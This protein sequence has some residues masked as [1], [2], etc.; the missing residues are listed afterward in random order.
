MANEI[1]VKVT[2]T[3][4]AAR[5]AFRDV[6]AEMSKMT[7]EFASNAKEAVNADNGL[8]RLLS[9]IDPVYNAEKKLSDAVGLLDQNLRLGN[10]TADAHAS[11]LAKVESVYG[12]ASG[13]AGGLSF[14]TSGV[15]REFI[16][17]G[18]EVISGNFS[19]IPGS[20]LVL[21]ERMG[22]LNLATIGT[23][24]A[25]AA[26]AFA[27]YEWA[28]HAERTAEA[29]NDLEAAERGFAQTA[30]LGKSQIEDLINSLR[31]LPGVN[32]E[33]AQSI[34]TEFARAH[35]VSGDQIRE[36][37]KYVNDFAFVTGQKAPAAAKE[38]A[39]A[40]NDPVTGVKELE[41]EF[42][43]FTPEQLAAIT[44]FNNLG[45]SA[46]AAAVIMEAVEARFKD[47]RENSLTPL[48]KTLNDVALAWD[49][50][51]NSANDEDGLAGLQAP[52]PH[53]TVSYDGDPGHL[54]DEEA[55]AS[56]AKS[57]ATKAERD[58]NDEIKR[59]IE[60][61]QQMGLQIAKRSELEG[62]LAQM[63]E[64]QRAA[65]EAGDT[66]D[67]A[68]FAQSAGEIQRQIAQLKE[69]GALS[70]ADRWKAELEEMKADHDVS[71]Q[72]ELSFWQAK[73]QIAG[74]GSR[75]YLTALREVNKLTK[76][77]QAEDRTTRRQ[78]LEDERKAA[79]DGYALAKEELDLKR[80]LHQITGAEEYTQ[81]KQ[82]KDQEYQLQR[83][84]LQQE[85]DLYE[86]GSKEKDKINNQLAAL[87]RRHILDTTKLENQAV[88][89][90]KKQWQSVAQPIN[91]ALTSAFRGV[92]S[93]SETMKQ[94]LGNIADALVSKM[95]DAGLK[96]AENWI[97]SQ[98][99]TQAATEAT[100]TATGV[101]TIAA[102]AAEAGA[103]AYASTAAI[104]IIGPELA[105]A[106]AATAY[107]AT[108]AFQGALGVASAAG[109]YDIPSGLNPL[110][111]LHQ[112][113]MVLP[114][115]LANRIRNMTAD[116]NGDTHVHFNVSTLDSAGVKKFF[117]KHGSTI[118]HTVASQA[119]NFNA[120][121]MLKAS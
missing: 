89:A 118:A 20:L 40:L 23:V 4:D 28:A 98:F 22:G 103:A 101:S 58:R 79:G 70:T 25:F 72:D 74:Q 86:Q 108:L 18:H 91:S 8:A 88:E 92:I 60:L 105:P 27:L 42:G 44:N 97:E 5:L 33:A 53:G 62:K 7:T 90:T 29:I 34:I 10:I 39:K 63:Q 43:L 95:L 17:L 19:R 93:G 67:A 30:P 113:E 55:A 14:A 56:V 50:F 31:Q 82:L 87:E 112:Q 15:T 59:G 75:E 116:G 106:A 51:W 84:A 36:I 65:E 120:P 107:G 94:A 45:E 6:A 16:V 64:A 24:G 83:A 11:A 78:D 96:I 13:G 81:L 99:L 76:Q 100:S 61:Q 110:T 69:K 26:A 115:N 54:S 71:K 41:K 117:A 35:N 49:N 9:R 57:L 46:N 104:P 38:L 47:M 68:N 21:G 66:K 12:E 119:R 32:R 3:T 80:D 109:G 1:N 2:A 85:L 114:A 77:V 121:A 48:Q 111:Q 52:M 73:V 37:A 102:S